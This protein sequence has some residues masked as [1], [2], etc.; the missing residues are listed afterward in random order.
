MYYCNDGQLWRALLA[1]DAENI[2]FHPHPSE[3]LC[4]LAVLENGY[5]LPVYP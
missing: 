4:L 5:A 3:E 2:R 1:T